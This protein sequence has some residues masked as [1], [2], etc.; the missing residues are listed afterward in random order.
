MVLASLVRLGAA[1]LVIGADQLFNSRSGQVAALTVRHV[2]PAICQYRCA[3][4]V[5]E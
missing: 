2:L 4:Q 3:D 5:I 1:A